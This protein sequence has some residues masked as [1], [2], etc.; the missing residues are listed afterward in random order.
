MYLDKNLTEQKSLASVNF[1]LL[2]SYGWLHKNL[3]LKKTP[4]NGN[5]CKEEA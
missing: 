5:N 4:K 3:P 2:F 1:L